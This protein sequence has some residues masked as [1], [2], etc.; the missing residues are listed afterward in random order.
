MEPTEKHYDSLRLLSDHPDADEDT[1]ES[2]LYSRSTQVGRL[3][4]SRIVKVTPWVTT[5]AFAILSLV[6][7]LH[8]PKTT[9]GLGSYETAFDT[10][11]GGLPRAFV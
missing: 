8:I 2:G 7:Y 5:A 11:P 6:F 3:W 9:G 1:S 4:P 10:D